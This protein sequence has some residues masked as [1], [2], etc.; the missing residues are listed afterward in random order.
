M[1]PTEHLLPEEIEALKADTTKLRLEV[2]LGLAVI[3]AL[4][5]GGLVW[6]MA[7]HPAPKGTGGLFGTTTPSGTDSGSNP[8]LSINEETHYYTV[9]ATYPSGT[10]LKATAGAA[11]DA[12]AVEVMKQF[13]L[14]T[15]SAFKENGD[16][17]HLT[18]EDKQI[19]T[20]GRK[21]A[22]S[23]EYTLKTSPKTISYVY[24][25]YMDTF[26]AHGN[27]YYRTFTFDRKTGASLVLG[28]I[29]SPGT[30]YLSLLSKKSREE[31][32]KQQAKQE[33]V[34]VSEIP[35]DFI[36]SGTLPEA[37]SFQN[38]YLDTHASLPSLPGGSVCTRSAA[39]R[40]PTCIA[41]YRHQRLV[42]LI[43][44]TVRSAS[45]NASR[46]AS[47]KTRRSHSHSSITRRS[48][49]VTYLF[50]RSDTW[51]ATKDSNR[52]SAQR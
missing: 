16:F 12:K 51:S 44:K 23:I 4:I 24:Q 8:P 1:E 47:S 21:Q 6:Y 30:D 49:R 2:A 36:N 15:I 7:T 45:R 33:E 28:D 40:H 13:E 14:N 26:G 17:N 52:K 22:V 35:M 27:I 29:F 34:P 10:P 19:Y 37:D 48:Y 20:D 5:I 11:A 9:E 42:S 32:P 18:A 41:R 25:I 39:G 38:W 46:S 50:P 31:L 43:W 3:I